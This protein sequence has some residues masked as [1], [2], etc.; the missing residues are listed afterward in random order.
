VIPI[1][2]GGDNRLW[3]TIM[4]N[5]GQK[6]MCNFVRIAELRWQITLR[7]LLEGPQIPIAPHLSAG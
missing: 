5:D 2:E 1:D 3:D 7:T 6:D 4:S